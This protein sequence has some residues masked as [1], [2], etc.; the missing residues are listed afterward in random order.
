MKIVFANDGV[1]EYASGLP[2]AIGGAERQQWLLARA[3]ASSGWSVTI[4][5]RNSLELGDSCR[6]A[7]VRFTGIGRGHPLPRWYKF[8]K[9]ERPDW[10]FWR[11]ADHLLGPAVALA[12]SAGVRTVFSAGFDRDVQPSR[13]LFRHPRWW[14]LYAWGL[15][16]TD[17]ILVQH[18]GQ[19]DLL[20]RQW[21][22]K[23]SI[24]P[25]I[26]GARV[27]SKPHFQRQNH[28]AWVGVLRQPKRP[29][30]LIDIASQLPAIRFVVCGGRS[31]FATPVGYSDEVITRLQAQ[32]NIEFLGTVPPHRSLQVIAE[33][34]LLL[35]TA[36]VE[37]FPNTFLE[38]WC[39]GT[40]VV[41][42]KIDPGGVIER[43]GLGS[44]THNVAGVAAEIGSL[45]NSPVRRD[46]I[47]RRAQHHAATAHSEAAAL[48][49][50]EH[51]IRPS[52]P[53]SP[54]ADALHLGKSRL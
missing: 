52:M 44:V 47:A 18:E 40:P 35:S 51:A 14:P 54:P 16:W 20:P 9:S 50:F 7:G 49:A 1:Y 19:L 8:L 38:A 29:D 24:V 39:C 6:I 11:C 34:A 48:G 28:V 45:L 31:S 32:P 26:C 33:A 13:A 42:L 25:S 21:Q 10:W 46:E 15:S 23:A 4:G 36:D 5:V 2:S 3:L 43:Q 41:S 12:K 37:G 22:D 17:R 53:M 27:E 30:L